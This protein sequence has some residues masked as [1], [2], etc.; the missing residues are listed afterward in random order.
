MWAERLARYLEVRGYSP[1]TITAYCADVRQAEL[2]FKSEFGK[3]IADL[4]VAELEQYLIVLSQKRYRPRTL[5]RKMMALR[6]LGR[7]LR[8]EGYPITWDAS[9]EVIPATATLPQFLSE[10][11][12]VAI[13]DWLE[14]IPT[15]WR[16]LRDKVVF[17][18]LITT[19][20]RRGE[21]LRVK[22]GDV[23][24]NGRWIRVM[25]KGGKERHLPLLE[26]MSALL[27][28]YLKERNARRPQV[29]H[30]IITDKL[31]PPYPAMIYR[32][33][34][35]LSYH[36]TGKIL[37]PHQLRHTFATVLLNRGVDVMTLK[38]LLGHASLA[39]TQIYT[40]TSID[41]LKKAI[42]QA[43]PHGTETIDKSA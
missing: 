1:H 17:L 24:M 32:I 27:H 18:L 29:P 8:W 39:A 37:S 34:R 20:M 35:R 28:S 13:T 21:L 38:E 22:V 19:G 5:N 31:R 12:V 6:A 25:G 7:F 3:T 33:V 42:I 41:Q 30:L 2:F 26:W 4:S 23:D 9:L 40:H 15:E 16:E 10:K 14:E 43:H 36:L 11:E